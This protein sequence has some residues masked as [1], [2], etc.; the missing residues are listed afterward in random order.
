MRFMI[1][2]FF[3]FV[4]LAITIA[5]GIGI[6]GKRSE[7]NQLF[8]A[9]SQEVSKTVPWEGFLFFEFDF[10]QS[11]RQEYESR[12]AEEHIAIGYTVVV[13]HRVWYVPKSHWPQAHR[14]AE[15]MQI[16]T[17]PPIAGIPVGQ[18]ICLVSQP[19]FEDGK[20]DAAFDAALEALRHGDSADDQSDEIIHDLTPE[21]QSIPDALHTLKECHLRSL[22]EAKGLELPKYDEW[23]RLK[24]TLSRL[25]QIAYLGDRI[26]LSTG[27]VNENGVVVPRC[28]L[29]MER[30]RKSL[31]P[32][33]EIGHEGTT[34]V[35]PFEELLKLKI[36][37]AEVPHLYKYF[38]TNWTILP[39]GDARNNDSPLHA[40]SRYCLCVVIN[41]AFQRRNGIREYDLTDEEWKDVDRISSLVQQ[42]LIDTVGANK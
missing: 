33:P 34:S 36:Q 24:Q 23:V 10:P 37:A 3:V 8:A 19:A 15:R 30:R 21:E 5:L 20:W 17:I 12:C 32:E 42:K 27:A 41:Q 7:Q 2:R 1:R 13:G 9:K 6:D 29:E 38:A 16:S 35:E 11:K 4:S 26:S 40:G 39:D 25:E 28:I 14:L 22:N 31:L 18:S